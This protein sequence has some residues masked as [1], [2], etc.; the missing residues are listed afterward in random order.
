MGITVHRPDVGQNLVSNTVDFSQVESS[1]NNPFNNSLPAEAK[2]KQP[3]TSG[4]GDAQPV[5]EEAA[6]PVTEEAAQP[7]KCDEQVAKPGMQV[8]IQTEHKDI[9]R[10]SIDDRLKRG[11][12]RAVKLETKDDFLYPAYVVDISA[13]GPVMPSL[14]ATF[15]WMT[16][17]K[18]ND[19]AELTTNMYLKTSDGI[20][21]IGVADSV[22]LRNVLDTFVRT[23]FGDKAKLL[24]SSGKSFKAYKSTSTDGLRMDL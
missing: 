5:T 17:D 7:V 22:L 16:S 18:Q 11:E 23:A 13:C 6:Q 10:E 2:L 24:Y 1:L 19:G 4:V 20:F 3:V 8:T 21:S 15:S 12:Y 14:L 9:V